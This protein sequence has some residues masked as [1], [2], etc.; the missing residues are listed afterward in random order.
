M[1]IGP[2]YIFMEISEEKQKELENNGMFKVYYDEYGLG[3][4]W[5]NKM[6]NDIKYDYTLEQFKSEFGIN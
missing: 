3:D 4:A 1:A 5:Y 2:K 6:A